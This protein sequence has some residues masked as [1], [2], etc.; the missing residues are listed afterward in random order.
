MPR[1]ASEARVLDRVGAALRFRLAQC[2]RGAGAVTGMGHRLA[3]PVNRRCRRSTRAVSKVDG[4]RLLRSWA[5]ATEGERRRGGTVASA[6]RGRMK[7]IM[8]L[9]N[10]QFVVLRALRHARGLATCE[11]LRQRREWKRQP[12]AEMGSRVAELGPGAMGNLAGRQLAGAAL[13]VQRHDPCPPTIRRGPLPASRSRR[14]SRRSR[15]RRRLRRGSLGGCGV[16]S[17][18][19]QRRMRWTGCGGTDGSPGRFA[20]RQTSDRSTSR[21]AR[22]IKER[23]RG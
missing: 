5:S 9:M 3:M 23:E 8:P 21:H 6:A 20:I 2:A 14:A 15:R 12:V 17:A 4:A 13:D 11:A 7:K 1:S 19:E 22:M 10:R 18:G 16:W